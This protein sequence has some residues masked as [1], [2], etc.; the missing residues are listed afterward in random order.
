MSSSVEVG[1][2]LIAGMSTLPRDVTKALG[3]VPRLLGA[4]TA[5]GN[6]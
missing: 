1:L 5:C 4:R 3:A 2:A 6:S